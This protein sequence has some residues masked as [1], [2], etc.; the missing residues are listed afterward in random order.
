MQIPGVKCGSVKIY[1]MSKTFIDTNILVYALDKAEPE[2]QLKARDLLRK[3]ESDHLGVIST[4]VLQEFYVVATRKLKVK[5]ELTKKIISSLSKFETVVINQPIIEK[6]IDIS[7]SNEISFW[8]ALIVASAVAAR[9][10]VIWTEDL[11]HG[12][13]IY[14]IKIENPFN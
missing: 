11:N 13:S 6:A 2:K 12:L 5:P 9:C 4:Q 14:K 10:K 8:N 7:M 3:T 1:M